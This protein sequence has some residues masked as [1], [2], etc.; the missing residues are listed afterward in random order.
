MAELLLGIRA[1]FGAFERPAVEQAAERGAPLF[2]GWAGGIFGGLD[3][4]PMPAP[5]RIEAVT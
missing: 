1:A 4:L 5:T 3:E 2:P